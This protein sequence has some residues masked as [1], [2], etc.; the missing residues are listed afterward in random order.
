[1]NMLPDLSALAARL[2]E[3]LGPKGVLSEPA[4]ITPRLTDWRGAFHG[5]APFIACPASTGEV[6]A[7]VS[8]CA[9]MR[10]PIVPQGG[11]TGLCGGATPDASGTQIPISLHR[12][13]KVR[14]LDP[15]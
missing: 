4:D 12:M 2:A 10:L 14:S 13:N 5:K 15:G 9:D 1:M 11:L 6:A 8:A 3:L 7:V